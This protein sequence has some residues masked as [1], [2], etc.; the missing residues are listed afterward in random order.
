MIVEDQTSIRE[1]L[2]E[3]VNALPEF[4]MV[5][6]AGRLDEGFRM[7]RR[8][9]PDVVILDWT[10]P[11]GGGAAFLRGLWEN[12]NVARV[13]VLSAGCEESAIR[14]ALTGGAR[15]YLEKGANLT[16]LLHALRTVAGGGAYFGASAAAEVER[17][18]K[19]DALSQA[20]L[21]Q[22]DLELSLVAPTGPGDFPPPP[23]A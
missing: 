15:G 5:G 7:V 21:E 19:A 6:E 22:S 9:R 11:G 23:A 3:M 17:M 14:A 2:V 16:E 18:L 4:E 20:R 1:M 8:L 10:F 13:L 12:R